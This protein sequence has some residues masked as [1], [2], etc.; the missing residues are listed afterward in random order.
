MIAP[1]ERLSPAR[2]VAPITLTEQLT[3]PVLGLFGNDDY[4]PTVAE[5]DATE[6]ELRRL[7]KSYEFYRYD[8]AGHAFMTTDRH[9][10]RPEQ[11]ADAWR[12]L[13]AFFHRYLASPAQQLVPKYI[14]PSPTVT[15]SGHGPLRPE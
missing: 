11:A 13:D 7:G 9:R 2:P 15:A 14:G 5:V 3:C 8:G 12:R 6:A 1:E 4:N 10:Y